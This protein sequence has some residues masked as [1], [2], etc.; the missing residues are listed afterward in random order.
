MTT[1]STIP[2]RRGRRRA[3]LL[4]GLVAA[5]TALLLLGA[6]SGASDSAGS[7]SGGNDM[8]AESADSSSGAA[9]GGS[10]SAEA[11]SSSAAS[12]A[13]PKEA[14][15]SAPLQQR[16]VI[17][18]STVSLV[19]EDVGAARRDVQRVVDQQRGL[20]S[21]EDTDTDADGVVAYARLVL[22]VPS[23]TFDETLDALE[24]I[25]ELRSSQ[26]TSEDVTTTVIDTE[27]RVRAQRR[28]LARVEQLLARADTLKDII[29]I[30]SQLTQRQGELDSLESQQAYLADQTS[31]STITV[32]IERTPEAAPKKKPEK[33]EAEATGFVAGLSGGLDALGAALTAVATVVGALL[34]FAVLL[35]LVGLPLWLVRRTV[36]RRRPVAGA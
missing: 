33:D 25:A 21:E 23:S 17:S 19:A 8:A 14:P 24:G 36:R 34:P 3:P 7:D 4:A 9:T 5:G 26:R 2:T 1:T 27:V 6:C 22:R 29:W 13:R 28:S 18:S 20:V 11:P 30:E 10:R 16:A 15:T 31:L 12:P 32:D 35:A